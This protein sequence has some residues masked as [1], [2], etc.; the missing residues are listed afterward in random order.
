MADFAGGLGDVA[1]A[2]GEHEEQGGEHDFKYA[3]ASKFCPFDT[4]LRAGVVFTKSG[5]QVERFLVIGNEGGDFVGF[6][7]QFF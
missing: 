3:A 5:E 2:A 1:G 6:G 7:D 4:G